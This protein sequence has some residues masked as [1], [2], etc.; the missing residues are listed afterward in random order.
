MKVVIEIRGGVADVITKSE[1]VEVEIRDFDIPEWN[2]EDENDN[3]S[4]DE[5]GKSY[6]KM[7][8]E[9]NTNF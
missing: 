8:W 1:G 2:D 4:V 9:S 5:D 6:V 3:L 7:I